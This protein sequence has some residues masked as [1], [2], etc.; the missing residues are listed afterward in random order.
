M[1][2]AVVCQ[3]RPTVVAPA[4]ISASIRRTVAPAAMLAVLEWFAR[5]A[6][7][8][9]PIAESTA[10]TGIHASRNV[11]HGRQTSAVPR[12]GS[13]VCAHRL[14]ALIRRALNRYCRLHRDTAAVRA[15]SAATD[16]DQSG[17]RGRR[18]HT[19]RSSPSVIAFVVPMASGMVL[20]HIWH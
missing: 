17:E 13:T 16:L 15:V 12:V 2:P 6:R 5:T 20:H 18:A 10:R 11:A 9:R 8:S 14:I 3:D 19:S 7:A 4:G 1:A